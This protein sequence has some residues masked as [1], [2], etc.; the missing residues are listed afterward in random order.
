MNAGYLVDANLLVLLIVGNVRRSLI[1]RHR[2]LK[3]YTVADYDLLLSQFGPE[4]KI[5]VTPNTLTETSNL[6]P[7]G[8]DDL[9]YLL[10]AELRSM[11][12]DSEEIVVLS[13]AASRVPEFRWLGLTDAVMVEIASSDIPLITSDLMLWSA[14]A[15]RDPY[16]AINFN[17]LRS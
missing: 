14:I 2:R 4:T 13:K 1:K 3:S 16:A 8:S 11:I 10:F 7:F 12:E 9:S 6:L 17:S 15:G 5:Y